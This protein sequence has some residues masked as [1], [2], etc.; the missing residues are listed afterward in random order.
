MSETKMT[1]IIQNK[2]RSLEKKI[3]NIRTLIAG[4]REIIVSIDTDEEPERFQRYLRWGMTALNK[5]EGHIMKLYDY[6]YPKCQ[7]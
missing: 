1:E 4:I 2:P 7:D 3:E 5:F 6:I